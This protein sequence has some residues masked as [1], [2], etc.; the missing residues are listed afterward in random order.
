MDN[1]MLLMLLALGGNS[2]DMTTILA[3]SDMLPAM[4]R[5]LLA[6]QGA[7]QRDSD[8]DKLAEE[9]AQAIRAAE[10]TRDSNSSDND[11]A[12][13]KQSVI[14]NSPQLKA[15]LDRLSAELRESIVDDS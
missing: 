14:A 7:Q 6:V 8:A 3:A 5:T 11:T 2:I 13:L 15:L 9:V 1:N 4:P 12:K 10:I